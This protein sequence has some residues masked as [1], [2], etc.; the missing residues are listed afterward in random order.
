M[1]PQ[2]PPE[3]SALLPQHVV[4]YIYSFVPHLKHKK[5]PPPSFTLSPKV[6]TDLRLIQYG[7][8][9]GKNE[10]YLRDLEDFMLDN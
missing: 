9:R 6:H 3:I 8:D 1:K 2:L 5:T 7:C 10:M 4:H